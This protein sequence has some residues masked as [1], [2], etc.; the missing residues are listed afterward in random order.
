[1]NQFSKFSI[2]LLLSLLVIGGLFRVIG[3]SETWELW[4]IPLKELNFADVRVITHG[5]DAIA[6]GK[7]P[8]V[9]NIGDPWGRQLNYPRIWQLLYLTGLSE[10]D[11]NLFGVTL[12]S[13]FL[14]GILIFVS[15]LRSTKA[16]I[17]IPLLL[18][19]A[20]MLGI[21]RGNTD[22]LIFFLLSLSIFFVEKRV[23]ISILPIILASVL[24]LYPILALSVF[25]G[26]EK[27]KAL[28]I[29]LISMSIMALYC[30][31]TLSDIL[32]IKESTLKGILYS[33]GAWVFE[34][35][36]S[37][38]HEP[39]QYYAK[40]LTVGLIAFVG[41]RLIYVLKKRIPIISDEQNTTELNAFRLGSSIF[42]GTFLLGINWDYRLMFWLFTVP[43]LLNWSENSTRGL[44]RQAI[45]TLIFMAISLWSMVLFRYSEGISYGSL[46]AFGT[47]EFADWFVFASLLFLFTRSLP[48]W[49][50]EIFGSLQK[51]LRKQQSR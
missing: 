10:E 5:A 26:H 37:K 15:K 31:A 41:V 36:V 30:F 39:W 38:I 42:V 32:L 48:E 51:I 4:N 44:S 8:L 13:L 47:N 40:I 12:I 27:K 14:S 46:I 28:T 21:E 33:H 34:N 18:S 22:L 43:Q 7:D 23:W 2:I 1:M 17:F 16:V 20:I 50:F 6:A 11:T 9:E 3:F 49:V 29:I 35:L 25:F 19:P 24:K 45:A